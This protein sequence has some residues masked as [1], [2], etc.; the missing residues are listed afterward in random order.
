MQLSSERSC[1][2][3]LNQ[4]DD[5]VTR[6]WTELFQGGGVPQ[7]EEMHAPPLRPLRA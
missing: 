6:E 7:I 1:N 2:R 4:P 5:Q 3:P